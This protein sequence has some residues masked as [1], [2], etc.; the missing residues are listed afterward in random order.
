MN[1]MPIR[2]RLMAAMTMAMVLLLAMPAAQAMPGGGR[3]GGYGQRQN[4]PQRE[5]REQREQRQF[6]PQRQDQADAPRPQ[7]LSPEERRQLRRDVHEAG[8]DLYP[9]RRF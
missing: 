3:F 5:Q 4:G 9:Q 1:R 6:P 7:R 2:R 8:R